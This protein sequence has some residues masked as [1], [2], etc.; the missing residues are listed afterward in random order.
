MKLVYENRYWTRYLKMNL[1]HF[2]QKEEMPPQ[3]KHYR[4]G[5]S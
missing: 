5:M 4:I 1:W 3:K 2:P